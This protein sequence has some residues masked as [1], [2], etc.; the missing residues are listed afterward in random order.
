MDLDGIVCAIEDRETV[1]AF[2]AEHY[3]KIFGAGGAAGR[4]HEEGSSPA[5]DRFTDEMDTFALRDQGR[6]VGAVMCHPT[7][8]SSYYIRSFALLP[9]AQARGVGSRFLQIA[10]PILR[11]AGV[12]RFEA[13]CA[14]GNAPSLTALLKA[15]FIVTGTVMSE[16][17]GYLL[18][19]TRFLDEDA[20]DAFHTQFSSMHIS[21]HPRRTP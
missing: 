20:L 16:R 5:K 8:W 11:D 13:E 10:A 18:R 1:L 2:V 4:F 14:P 15:G 7:D 9:E 19:L 6:M 3:S 12:A 17:W 21:N